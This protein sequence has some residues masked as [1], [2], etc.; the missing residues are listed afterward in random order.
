MAAQGGTGVPLSSS[1]EHPS[2][3]SQH[4]RAGVMLPLLPPGMARS[5]Q[6]PPKPE[7][8][9]WG[10]GEQGWGSPSASIFQSLHLLGDNTFNFHHTKNMS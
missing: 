7:Q 4:P 9:S 1:L 10:S 2:A 8:G 5:Q 3:P 6:C